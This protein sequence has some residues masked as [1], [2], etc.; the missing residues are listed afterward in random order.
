VL[1]SLYLAKIFCATGS[2]QGRKTSEAASMSTRSRNEAASAKEALTSMTAGRDGNGGVT[3]ASPPEPFDFDAK[4]RDAE[5]GNE[6]LPVLDDLEHEYADEEDDD[7]ET[8]FT[9][10]DRAD[11]PILEARVTR[12]SRETFHSLREIRNR[13]L[14]KLYQDEQGNR[15]YKSFGGK[16][17]VAYVKAR[18]GFS[19]N[20]ATRGLNWLRVMETFDRLGIE[21]PPLAVDAAQALNPSNLK[22]AGGLLAVTRLRAS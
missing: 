6:S 21:P 19:P 12:A 17:G 1:L 16:K 11:L 10:K 8:E 5:T 18:F 7:S 15:L 9:A 22:Q 13:K 14:W 20:W 4:E 2:G 3:A